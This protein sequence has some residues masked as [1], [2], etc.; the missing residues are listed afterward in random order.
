MIPYLIYIHGFNS[1]D[2]S[3]KAEII[4]RR[5]EQLNCVD[6]FLSP[7]LSWE[8]KQAIFELE[9]LIEDK[10]KSGVVTLCGS[11][12]GGFYATYLSQKY[13][14]KSVLINPVVEAHGLLEPYLGPQYNPYT[15]EK[16]FLTD[17]H[18]EQLLEMEVGTINDEL[19]W[20]L[21]QEGDETLDFRKALKKYPTVK[22]VLETQ[23]S[24][25]FDD[26]ERFVDEIL[27]YSNLLPNQ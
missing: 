14:V 6:A 16:Y 21:L 27:I 3:Q 22:T 19:F 25:R 20:L 2:K 7:C 4:K 15:N 17:Q 11:S 12:L 1:S 9:A 8:P 5:C 10:L 23:G 18:I 13:S 24:H 26:F